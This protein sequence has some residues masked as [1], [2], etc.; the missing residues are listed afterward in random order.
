MARNPQAEGASKSLIL[1]AREIDDFLAGLG[2]QPTSSGLR[3]QYRLILSK[4]GAHWYRRGFRRGC[5]ESQ[6]TFT[7]TGRFPKKVA[8]DARRDFFD[9]RKRPVTVSWTKR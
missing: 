5:L 1:I 6:R 7:K 2:I 3:K 4:F 8:Y 9:G